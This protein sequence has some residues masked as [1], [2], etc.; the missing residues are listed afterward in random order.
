MDTAELNLA[1]MTATTRRIDVLTSLGADA[2][3]QWHYPETVT[4][5]VSANA[6]YVATDDDVTDDDWRAAV[7]LVRSEGIAGDIGE[8]GYAG[9][10]VWVWCLPLTAERR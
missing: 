8:P 5:A 2:S 4:V 1:M 10:G 3:A 9:H 6:V 7:R